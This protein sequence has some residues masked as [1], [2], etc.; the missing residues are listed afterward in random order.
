MTAQGAALDEVAGS[1]LRRLLAP[2]KT[3]N[4]AGVK[5]GGSVPLCEAPNRESRPK[6]GGPVCI[7]DIDGTGVAAR[8]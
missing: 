5:V 3:F 4:C 2:K 8:Y 1:K 6:W 7:F